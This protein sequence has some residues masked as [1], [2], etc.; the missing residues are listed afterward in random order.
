MPYSS[1]QFWIVTVI[2]FLAIG[3]LVRPFFPRWRKNSCCSKAAKPKN[4]LG[5][6]KRIAE[7]ASIDK[8]KEEGFAKIKLSIVRFGN[9]WASQGSAIPL[10][11]EQIRSNKPI[12][13]TNLK[14][15]RYFM[16]IREACNL[17]IQSCQLK[18]KNKIFILKMGNQIKILNISREVNC[19]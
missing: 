3:T 12:T 8:L 17:V 4:V 10:F 18:A 19:C 9:V 16:T 11:V 14:A 13:I 1:W 2:L 5:F 15:K 6:S 7:I